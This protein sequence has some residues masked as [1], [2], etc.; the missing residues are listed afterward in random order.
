MVLSSP[1]QYVSAE[2]LIVSIRGA[3]ALTTSYTA[4]DSIDISYAKSMLLVITVLGTGI[5]NSQ[6][7]V[8]FSDSFGSVWYDLCHLDSVATANPNVIITVFELGGSTVNICIPII[9]PGAALMRTMNKANANNG[10]H[11]VGVIRGNS[12]GSFPMVNGS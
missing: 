12:V 4:S 2:N 5:A 1:E 3:T 7:K 8:Q 9:N 10:A 6:M 11:S